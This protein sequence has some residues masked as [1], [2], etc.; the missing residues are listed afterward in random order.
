MQPLYS[1]PGHKWRM[2]QHLRS[3][4]IA[5]GLA[6]TFSLYAPGQQGQTGTTPSTS[7][8]PSQSGSTA[9]TPTGR[10]DSASSSRNR[11]DEPKSMVGPAEQR[12]MNEAAEGSMAEIQLAQ[13]AAKKGQSEQVK[14]LA[15]RIEQDHT[16]A[17]KELQAIASKRGVSLPTSPSPKHQEHMAKLEKL[18]GAAFD[19]QYARMM[20]SDHKKEISKFQRASNDLLDTDLKA[21]AS[22]TLPNLQEHLQMAQAAANQKTSDAGTRSR[23]ASSTSDS[24]TDSTRK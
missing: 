8:T 2:T 14:S 16:T 13:L 24:T 23:S 5:A 9:Q 20:V 7:G 12:F 1:R 22:K 11:M 17:S 21:F 19:R 6:L 15:S 3:T 4:A 10:T 18:D